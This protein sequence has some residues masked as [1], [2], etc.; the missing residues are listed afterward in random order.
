M[1]LSRF[2]VRREPT[3]D[4]AARTLSAL[5][6]HARVLAAKTDHERQKARTRQLRHEKGLPALE[7]FE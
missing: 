1:I 6:H 2:L 7:I 3:P 4:H 5:A